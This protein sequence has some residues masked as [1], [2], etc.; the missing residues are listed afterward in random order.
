MLEGGVRLSRFKAPP[1]IFR[2]CDIPEI[3]FTVILLIASMNKVVLSSFVKIGK[4]GIGHDKFDDSFR[5]EYSY[6][7]LRGRVLSSFV[8][9]GKRDRT[10]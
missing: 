9:I 3:N 7:N 2:P 5:Y 6:N 8:K 1:Q 4:I 10:C